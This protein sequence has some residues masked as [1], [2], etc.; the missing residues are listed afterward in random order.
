MARISARQLEPTERSTLD[1]VPDPM[2]VPAVRRRVFA[3]CAIKSAKLNAISRP[4]A[5]PIRSP[6]RQMLSCMSTRRS[7]QASPSSSGVTAIGPKLVEGLAWR[8]PNPVRTSRAPIAR[9]LQSLI[10]TSSR[11]CVPHCADDFCHRHLVDDHTELALKIDSVRLGHKGHVGLRSEKI[12]TRSLVH[13]RD[14]VKIRKMAA[15]RR[16][17]PSAA[18]D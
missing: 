2:I 9:R 6:L 1:T 5:A 8:K 14:R 3:A 10:C 12:V 17:D 7:R 16:Q 15:C 18:R 4:E 13:H 11:M